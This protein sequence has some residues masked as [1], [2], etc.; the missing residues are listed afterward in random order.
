MPC[1]NCNRGRED[2]DLKVIPF[3]EHEL[4]MYRKERLFTAWIAGLAAALVLSNLA[5]ILVLIK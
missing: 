4:E 2:N 1:H 5:W 3:V